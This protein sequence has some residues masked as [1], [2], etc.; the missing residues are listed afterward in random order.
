MLPKEYLVKHG[1]LKEITRGRLS[2]AN[3]Q[4]LKEAVANGAKITGYEIEKSGVSVS[5]V[6]PDTFV[7]YVCPSDY[8]FPETEYKVTTPKDFPFPKGVGMRN[9]CDTCHVSLVNHLCDNPR[10][11]GYTVT[12]ERKR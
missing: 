6:N 8:R 7:E 1:Y 5:K 2:L 12:I 3:I 4:I 9:V 10:L 11:F